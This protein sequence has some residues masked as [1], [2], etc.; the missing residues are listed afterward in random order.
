M[1]ETLAGKETLKV[2]PVIVVDIDGVLF[3]TPRQLLLRTG[4]QAKRA[5]RWSKFLTYSRGNV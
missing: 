5:G 2:R 1:T 4:R 3:D